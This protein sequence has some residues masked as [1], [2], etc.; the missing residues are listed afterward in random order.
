M[1]NVTKYHKSLIRKAEK[2][3]RIFLRSKVDEKTEM[4][5]R[6]VEKSSIFNN[7]CMRDIH[8]KLNDLESA[9]RLTLEEC[10][11]LEKLVDTIIRD[12]CMAISREKQVHVI[13][14]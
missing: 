2:E 11:W 9:Y 10:N 3:E 13:M 7:L 1:N 14:E 12:T 4:I 6:M 5:F 8:K